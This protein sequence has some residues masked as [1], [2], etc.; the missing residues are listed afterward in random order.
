MS[1]F[2][3]GLIKN[4]KRCDFYDETGTLEMVESLGENARRML[5]IGILQDELVKMGFKSGIKTI[6][7]WNIDNE[8]KRL[9]LS[10]YFDNDVIE[11]V[12]F[13]GE[14]VARFSYDSPT[15]QEDVINKVKE[16]IN[17]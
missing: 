6:S 10:I 11:V 4:I 13:N 15:W 5:E 2:I 9:F 12:N 17:E 7:T 3:D 14:V 8:D 16:L 1:D